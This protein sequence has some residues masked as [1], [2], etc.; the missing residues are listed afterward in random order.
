[1]FRDQSEGGVGGG[2][3]IAPGLVAV[4]HRVLHRKTE[5]TARRHHGATVERDRHRFA[6]AERA[7]TFAD[8]VGGITRRLIE[9]LSDSARGVGHL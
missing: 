3:A 8:P 9:R 2:R 7:R 6:S 1:M 5:R 4:D